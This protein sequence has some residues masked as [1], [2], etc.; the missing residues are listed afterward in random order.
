LEKAAGKSPFYIITGRRFLKNAG[1]AKCLN[2]N[3]INCG[4]KA[5]EVP[6]CVNPLNV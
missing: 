1:F 4:K 5:K 2:F 6:V 3:Q